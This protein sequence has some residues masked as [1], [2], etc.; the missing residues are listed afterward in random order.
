MTTRATLIKLLHAGARKLFSDDETRRAWQRMRTCRSGCKEPCRD[1]DS[2]TGHSSCTTMTF[3]DLENLVAELRRKKVLKPMQRSTN[4]QAR[5]IYAMWKSMYDAGHIH[6]GSLQA[7][8]RYCHRM[9]GRYRPEWLSPDDAN[10][11]IES[12]KQW[13]RRMEASA[14]AR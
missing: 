8:G 5:K 11:V 10:R 7:L 6:D 9:T 3:T 4:P 12:L 14:N 13:Q 1:L 2:C